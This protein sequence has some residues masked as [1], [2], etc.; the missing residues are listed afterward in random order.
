MN[1]SADIKNWL[2]EIVNRNLKA[3]ATSDDDL[4]ITD[5]I[6][7]TIDTGTN[8]PFKERGRPVPYGAREFLEK[9]IAKYL[10][11]GI[12][13]PADP[14]Q[15]PYTS[16]VVVVPKKDGT[17][18]MCVDY[19]RL[20]TQTVKDNYNLPRIDEIFVALHDKKHFISMDLLMGYHQVRVSA[21]D[22]AKT[23]FSTHMGLFQFNVMPFGLCNAP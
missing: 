9:E 13:S 1:V 11:L 5:R 8:V 22:R 4:S 2:V 7:H 18:R 23:A 12:I 10:K 17:Y 14:G 15:C 3:F 20:N 19:R 6:E 21:A 16:S